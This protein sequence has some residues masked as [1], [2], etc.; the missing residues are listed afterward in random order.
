LLYRRRK[1]GGAGG[2]EQAVAMAMRTLAGIFE[3]RIL[4]PV[5]IRPRPQPSIKIRSR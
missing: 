2:T 3:Q 4:V 5:P 1:P